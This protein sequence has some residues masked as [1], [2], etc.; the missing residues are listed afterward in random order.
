MAGT[1]TSAWRRGVIVLAAIIIPLSP[2]TALAAKGHALWTG[3]LGGHGE[4]DIRVTEGT[5][6]VAGGYH[7]PSSV[8]DLDDCAQHRRCRPGWR[9]PKG[10]SEALALHGGTLYTTREHKLVAYPYPCPSRCRP[11]WTDVLGPLGRHSHEHSWK[12]P[13]DWLDTPVVHAGVVYLG[14]QTQTTSHPGEN[15][16]RLY[17]YPAVCERRRGCDLLWRSQILRGAVTPVIEDGLVFEASASGLFVFDEGC[18]SD[19]GVCGP[20]WWDRSGT[21]RESMLLTDPSFSSGEVSVASI[22]DAGGGDGRPA[23]IFAYPIRCRADGERC[24]PSLRDTIAERTHRFTSFVLG[25]EAAHHLVFVSGVG[26]PILAYPLGCAHASCRPTR[27]YA[28]PRASLEDWTVGRGEVVVATHHNDVIAFPAN[29]EGQRRC[30]SSWSWQAP[31]AV[32]DLQIQRGIV[33][34]STKHAV[35]ALAASR[36]NGTHHR[37]PFW[38]WSADASLDA[39]VTV[40]RDSVLVSAGQRLFALATP[41]GRS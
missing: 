14:A 29:C 33:Y 32:Q 38:R 11:L 21:D 4:T 9:S 36:G 7:A 13:P 23:R 20:L 10:I 27:V 35:Y 16:G 15:L 24:R 22:H 6:L 34:A 28:A 1:E 37:H 12:A 2:A 26:G 8:F 41:R 5:V 39:P 25:P 17:A 40:N 3:S 30:A 19:G 31:D 18:R